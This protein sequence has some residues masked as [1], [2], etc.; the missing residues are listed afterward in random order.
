[1]KAISGIVLWVTGWMTKMPKYFE[2]ITPVGAKAAKKAVCTE[3]GGNIEFVRG[4]GKR[5]SSIQKS[6]ET[7][8]EYLER[9]KNC[10]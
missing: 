7:L 1:M 8:E 2:E 5:K 6:M 4:I 3:A 10:T 9:L